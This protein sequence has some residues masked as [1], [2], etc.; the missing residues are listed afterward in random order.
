M[1]CCQGYFSSLASP[2]RLELPLP[3]LE[4]GCLFQLD[5]EEMFREQDFYEI[6]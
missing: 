5:Y 3:H 4:D 2:G 1:F 6:A